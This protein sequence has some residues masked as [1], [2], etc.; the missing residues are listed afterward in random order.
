MNPSGSVTSLWRYPVKSMLGEEMDSAQVV[1]SGFYGNRCYALVDAETSRLVSAKNP[2]KWGRMF[3]C[4]SRVLDGAS[5]GPGL[6]MVRITLPEGKEFDIR[7]G[8]YREAEQALSSLLGRPVSFT[9]AKPEPREVVIEQYHPEIDGEKLRGQI[10]EFVRSSDAQVGTF[11]DMAAV[12]LLTTSTLR[13][14]KGL[15]PGGDFNPL[16]FR[17][18]ILV[19]TGEAEGFPEREWVGKTLLIGDVKLEVFAECGRCVMT[20]LPQGEIESDTG[21]LSTVRRF[22]RGKTGVFASVLKGGKIMMG[23]QVYTSA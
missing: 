13:T 2:A 5:G 6:P 8:E 16:R 7:E 18:N 21:I 22:N 14:L 12:H 17:P 11:T 9:A 20:T 4:R 23:D 10:T 1:W 19:E 15:S 3:E